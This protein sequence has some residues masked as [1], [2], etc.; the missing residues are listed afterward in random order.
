M[1]HAHKSI[2]ELIAEEEKK[3]EQAKARIA[4]LKAQQR[5]EDR[6]RDNHRKIVVGAAV[7]AHVRMDSR[8]REQVREAL[9]KAVTDPRQRAVI[10]DLLDEQAFLAAMRAAAK[11]ADGEIKETETAETGTDE[12]ARPL[13]PSKAAVEAKGAR[14]A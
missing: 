2:E 5:S 13:Q 1:P 7:I 4:E 10:P 12:T 6:K 8:F 11:K 9:N 3:S 14:P